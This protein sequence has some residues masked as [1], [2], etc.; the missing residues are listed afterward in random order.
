MHNVKII[1][2]TMHSPQRITAVL[3][4][5]YRPSRRR[6][7]STSAYARYLRRDLLR[8]F[9]SSYRPLHAPPSH[10]KGLPLGSLTILGSSASAAAWSATAMP[11][12]PNCY[13]QRSLPKSPGPC[14]RQSFRVAWVDEVALA[15]VDFG[16]VH[17]SVGVNL[18]RSSTACWR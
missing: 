13:P 4:Q 16:L 6:W 7:T 14:L 18:L 5:R 8:G 17:T 2:S 15:T 11:E 9:F 10:P 3:F 1:A 12:I